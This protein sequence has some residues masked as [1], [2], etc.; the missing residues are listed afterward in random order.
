[1]ACIIWFSL[2]TNYN[3]DLSSR[4]VETE[5]KVDEYVPLVSPV[6]LPTRANEGK[7]SF[8]SSESTSSQQSVVSTPF[9]EENFRGIFPAISYNAS[10]S[11]K[12]KEGRIHDSHMISSPHITTSSHEKQA[13][14]CEPTIRLAEYPFQVVYQHETLLDAQVLTT[15][16]CSPEECS[17]NI[18]SNVDTKFLGHFRVVYEYTCGEEMALVVKYVYVKQIPYTTMYFRNG[19]LYTHFSDP[20]RKPDGK[21]LDIESFHVSRVDI[22]SMDER[23]VK[24]D[25]FKQWQQSS[26]E[27]GLAGDDLLPVSHAILRVRI[28]GCVDAQYPFGRCDEMNEVKMYTPAGWEAV[29][30]SSRGGNGKQPSINPDLNLFQFFWF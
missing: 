10:M 29:I 17:L 23:R 26:M 30:H 19:I 8:L 4:Q 11:L 15:Q 7:S 1:M 25:M 14:F 2:F 16:Q 21:L 18:N 6:I 27:I 24:A 28:V 13:S 9:M 12:D 22:S 3:V 5:Y 20:V